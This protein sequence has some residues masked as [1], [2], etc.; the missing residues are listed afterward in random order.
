MT[1]LRNTPV[2]ILA[3]GRTPSWMETLF[4]V[5]C[6]A[7]LP[8]NGRPVIHWSLRYLKS[9][10]CKTLKICIRSD[11]LRLPDFVGRVFSDQFEIDFIHPDQDRGAGYSLNAALKELQSDSDALIIL[12][13][14]LFSLPQGIEFD[15]EASFV[16][17]D[18]A[19]RSSRWC[20]AR[21]D[22]NG[23][24]KEWINNPTTNPDNLPALIGVYYLHRIGL[25]QINLERCAAEQS[26]NLSISDALDPYLCEGKGVVALHPS[27]W[28]D[29]G[30]FDL[31]T[32][33]RQ[34]L[35][36]SRSFNTI[37]ID[38]NKGTLT[39]TSTDRKKFRNEINYYRLLPNDLSLMF[40]RLIDF[41]CE[42]AP[43]SMTLEYY[44]YPTLSEKLVFEELDERWW[45]PVVSR[46]GVVIDSFAS[47][48]AHFDSN[49]ISDFYWSKTLD[50]IDAFEAQ[51][52]ECLSLVRSDVMLING[53]Q[54]FG[55]NHLKPRFS[56][57]LKFIGRNA[58][59]AAI[60]GDFCFT[61]ILID[62]LTRIIKLIDP[63]G[64]LG[65]TGI[66]G[67]LQYDAA[68]LLHSVHGGYDFIVHDMFSIERNSYGWKLDIFRSESSRRVLSHL[69]EMLSERFN[70]HSVKLIESLLFLSMPPLHQDFPD[71]Q[72]AMW[73]RGIQLANEALDSLG[74]IRFT[75]EI[76]QHD[77]FSLDIDSKDCPPFEQVEKS[78]LVD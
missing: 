28:M 5:S 56:A 47:H 62:P 72:T 12:G 36:Q 54:Y 17:V 14:T 55:W 42:A 16:L 60:H 76:F 7:M 74:V 70:L 18:Q 75:K 25:A 52:K 73:V 31:L 59:G 9:I 48:E 24:I 26:G 34:H 77:E 19:D 45:K 64:S 67:D 58:K 39:K 22:K 35:I 33:S 15:K 8:I 10:G 44:P 23:L 41:N 37:S 78:V 61:N 32:S 13:D 71:R 21:L 29:C 63:R 43:L 20:V 66:Y 4:G 2:I 69:H 1:D 46:L 49:L 3:A 57:L 40:P 6:V 51:N 30:N 50:R 38:S 11:E 68:K 65:E 27:E 53:E